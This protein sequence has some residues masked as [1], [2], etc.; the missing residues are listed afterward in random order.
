MQDSR[1]ATRPRRPSI[2]EEAVKLLTL[3][4]N[5]INPMK[6]SYWRRLTRSADVV[7]TA[8][9]MR[10]CD[11]LHPGRSSGPCRQGNACQCELWSEVYAEG[12]PLLEALALMGDDT[13]SQEEAPD[14]LVGTPGAFLHLSL[15]PRT[16]PVG[17]HPAPVAIQEQVARLDV[18][19]LLLLA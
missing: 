4:E 12:R 5:D 11:E 6:A 17:R 15:D 19:H 9:C 16:E 13:V 1:S 10:L 8:H 18:S 7:M 2:L 3:E 14:R